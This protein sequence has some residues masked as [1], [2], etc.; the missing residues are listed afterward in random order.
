MF[1]AQNNKVD[2]EDDDNDDDDDEKEEGG[3]KL[4]GDEYAYSLDSGHC[5][6][7]VHLSPKSPSC[8]Y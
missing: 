8:I 6:P 5:F 2:D 4:G 7:S 3:R 1:S